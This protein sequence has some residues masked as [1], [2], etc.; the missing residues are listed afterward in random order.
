MPSL[1]SFLP[2][3]KPGV[4]ALDEERRDAAVAG[5]GIDGRE[6]DEEVGLVAVGDPELAAVEDEAV[7]ALGGARGQRERVAAGA[8]LRQRVGADG[9]LREPGQVVLLLRR[10]CPS[11]AA[12]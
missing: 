1:S 7:A 3:V 12:R 6:D 2:T 11:A 10:R 4:A 8:G 5:L 9:L